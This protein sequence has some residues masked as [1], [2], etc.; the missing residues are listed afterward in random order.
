[1]DC[2]LGTSQGLETK[3]TGDPET[4]ERDIPRQFFP[5]RLREVWRNG[6]RHARMSEHAGDVMRARLGPALEFPEDY[7]SVIKMLNDA[8]LDTIETN[9]AESTHDL[10]G[11]NKTCQLLL[12]AQTVLQ[13]QYRSGWSDQRGQQAAELGVGSRLQGD[14]D[15][16]CMADFHGRPGAFRPDLKIALGTADENSLATDGL[17]IRPQQEMDLLARPGE[18]GPVKAADGATTNDSDLHKRLGFS[19][20]LFSNRKGTLSVLRVPL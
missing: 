16:I 4:I 15:Q 14:D 7:L 20:P 19:N 9:E 3:G 12:V 1:M 13:R 5:M 10:F 8:W 2:G 18:F 11:R 17:V 6:A